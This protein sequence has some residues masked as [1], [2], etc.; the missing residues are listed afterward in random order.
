MLTEIERMQMDMRLERAREAARRSIDDA[1]D[2]AEWLDDT[3][4]N[5]P[6]DPQET[7]RQLEELARDTCDQDLRRTGPRLAELALAFIEWRRKGGFDPFTPPNEAVAT[8]PPG[9][10][11]K[12]IR[13]GVVVYNPTKHTDHEALDWAISTGLPDPS[14]AVHLRQ[15]VTPHQADLLLKAL[16]FLDGDTPVITAPVDVTDL[17]LLWRVA[18]TVQRVR[19]VGG[20][21]R[22]DSIK[23]I[24]EISSEPCP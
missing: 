4:E 5:K 19:W 6:M 15:G 12:P 24:L 10:R 14:C 22:V 21:T 13:L 7:I 9:A 11:G 8:P 1:L 3:E 23:E 17:A 2:R 16:S 18:N 20:S